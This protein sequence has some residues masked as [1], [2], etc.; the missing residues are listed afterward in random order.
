MARVPLTSAPVDEDFTRDANEGAMAQAA[1]PDDE[2]IRE[3]VPQTPDFNGLAYTVS[4]AGHLEA[5]V[6]SSPPDLGLGPIEA[7]AWLPTLEAMP[8]GSA[9]SQLGSRLGPVGAS[10][11]D[12][13]CVSVQFCPDNGAAWWLTCVYDLK[14]TRKKFSFCRNSGIPV[15]IALAHGWL[16]EI[17]ILSIGMRTKIMPT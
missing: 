17:S 14:E 5:R 7:C 2:E 6:V 10:R 8:L 15:L 9:F 3:V 16:R 13:H 1:H 4:W 12:H 11:V